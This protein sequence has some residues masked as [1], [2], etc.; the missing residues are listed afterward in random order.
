MLVGLTAGQLGFGGFRSVR[1]QMIQSGLLA[2]AAGLI[3]LA[4]PLRAAFLG[5][6][7]PAL[8][9][10]LA[11]GAALGAAPLGAASFVLVGIAGPRFS[12]QPDWLAAGP[13][14]A[15]VALGSIL[16]CAATLPLLARWRAPY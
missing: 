16:G 6:L 3:A 12:C 9:H 13:T 11:A 10:G 2:L 5:R 4:G 8:A 14:V 1:L 7:T 15:Y